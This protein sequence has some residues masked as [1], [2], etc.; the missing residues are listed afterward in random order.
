MSLWRLYIDECGDHLM[1][2]HL[3]TEQ[4]RYLSLTGV[5]IE[6]SEL[7]KTIR[8]EMEAFKRRHFDYDAD[9]NLVLH[10]NDI[11][12][13][14]RRF[15]VLRDEGKR[16]AFD[17]DLIDHL[18]RWRFGVVTVVLDKQS[19]FL[20]SYRSLRH[21]Y[22]YCL[23]VVVERFR[24][25]VGRS[26][27]HQGDVLAEARGK[28]ENAELKRAY[29]HLWSHGS[30]Y[31]SAAV[32]QR[33]LTSRQIKIKKKEANVEGLQ[34]ADLIAHPTRKQVLLNR[35][36]TTGGLSPFSERVIQTVRPKWDARYNR[37]FLS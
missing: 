26:G 16:E 21:A 14:S 23:H 31:L 12:R 28:K 33:F 2:A 37:V 32:M 6:R 25:A 4:K 18:E 35:G 15:Y 13:R 8:P 24:G 30:K 22:H 20:K 5:W 19:H 17:S 10:R 34:L 3:P 1:A 11:V 27:F 36:K 7:V 9:E 29:N